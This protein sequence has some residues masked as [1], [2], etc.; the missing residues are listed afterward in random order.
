MRDLRGGERRITSFVS[1]LTHFGVFRMTQV[2]TPIPSATLIDVERSFLPVAQM[3]QVSRVTAFEE[4]CIDGEVDLGSHHWVWPQHFPDDPIFPG[5]LMVEA[6]GQ[7]I[8]LWAW[9]NG[10]RGR[11]RMMRAA[12]EFQRPVSRWTPKLVLRGLVRRKRHLY[13]GSVE[14]WAEQTRVANVEAVLVVLDPV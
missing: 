9:G 8:A 4:A 13:F 12:A 7:L 2:M 6:A 10:A 1:N 5:S 11:P 14:V 3:R